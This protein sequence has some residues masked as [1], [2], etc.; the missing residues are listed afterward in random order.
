VTLP[1]PAQRADKWI[2]RAAT[3]IVAG[4]AGIAGAISY[5]HMRQLAAAHGDTGWHA[6]AFPLSVDGV[7]IVASLVTQRPPHTAPGHPPG[8]TSACHLTAARPRSWPPITTGGQEHATARTSS[9]RSPTNRPPTTCPLQG[10][11]S[12][13]QTGT[14]RS[15][16]QTCRAQDVA[17]CRGSRP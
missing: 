8:R 5:S 2:S 6:H 3:A 15:S 11:A 9:N 4:L 17:K 12:G 16:G 13:R 10:T 7:E 1:A 14:W